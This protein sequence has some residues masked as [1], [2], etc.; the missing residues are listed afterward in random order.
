MA[1]FG[2]IGLEPTGSVTKEINCEKVELNWLRIAY[3]NISLLSGVR[4]F[5]KFRC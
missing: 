1:Y 5:G 4:D 3:S 2:V